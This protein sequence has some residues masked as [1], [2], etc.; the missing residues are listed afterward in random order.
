MLTKIQKEIPKQLQTCFRRNCFTVWN[1]HCCICNTISKK[2]ECQGNMRLRSCQIFLQVLSLFEQQ[3][4]LFP[5]SV[6]TA[7]STMELCLGTPSCCCS[8]RI[9]NNDLDRSM[10]C[11]DKDRSVR[12]LSLSLC[13]L[14]TTVVTTMCT[15]VKG[16]EK[17]PCLATVKKETSRWASGQERWV[18]VY[19][20][21]GGIFWKLM[22]HLGFSQN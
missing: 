14:V 4:C 10:C 1:I 11:S 18:T 17:S 8:Q 9:Q 6:Y 13:M 2:G 16:A 5:Y 22:R 20:R 21:V 15:C 19:R 7:P 3:R 12:A